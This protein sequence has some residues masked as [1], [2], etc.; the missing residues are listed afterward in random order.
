MS[1]ANRP[2]AWLGGTPAGVLS[3]RYGEGM[4]LVKLYFPGEIVEDTGHLA[5]LGA[6][7]IAEILANGSGTLE[8]ELDL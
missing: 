5:A 4:R 6:E 7:R 1:K 8:L 3:V 2:F